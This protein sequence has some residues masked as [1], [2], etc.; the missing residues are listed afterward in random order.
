MKIVITDADTGNE[1]LTSARCAEVA[2]VS[3]TTWTGYVARG[4]APEPTAHLNARTPLWDAAEVQSWTDSRPGRGARTDLDDRRARVGS[5][6]DMVRSVRR[7]IRK[8]PDN[9]TVAQVITDE[10]DD[11]ATN[12]GVSPA[13]IAEVRAAVEALQLND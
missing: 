13:E 4:R 9:E 2:G 8:R 7:Q 12:Y 6:D 1:L 3:P 5:V 10:L 11:L